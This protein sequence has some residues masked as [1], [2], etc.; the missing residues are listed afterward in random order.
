M[1]SLK[2]GVIEQ[3]RAKG[4]IKSVVKNELKHSHYVQCISDQKNVIRQQNMIQSRKHQLYI[5]SVKKIALSAFD[6][7]RFVMDNGVD[8]L[9]FGHYRIKIMTTN[10]Q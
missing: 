4:T 9:A 5:A 7:K 10:A 8:T 6:D 1:Y 2:Y 3:K